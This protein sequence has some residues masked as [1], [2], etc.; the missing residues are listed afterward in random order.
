MIV[1]LIG[2]KQ[3]Y[4]TVIYLKLIAIMFKDSNIYCHFA[5][6]AYFILD[7]TYI[8]ALSLKNAQVYFYQTGKKIVVRGDSGC[9]GVWPG[10]SRGICGDDGHMP[11]YAKLDS[12]LGLSGLDSWVVQGRLQRSEMASLVKDGGGPVGGQSPS[13]A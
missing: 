13:P 5:I 2:L 12:E 4:A 1:I 7:N 11:C 3:K 6:L 8:A 9:Q 10:C